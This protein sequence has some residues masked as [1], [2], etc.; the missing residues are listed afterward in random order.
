[1]SYLL[2][3][4]L[5]MMRNYKGLEYNQWRSNNDLPYKAIDGDRFQDW[6]DLLNDSNYNE[7]G[8]LDQDS[9]RYANVAN[10]PSQA[11]CARWML[12]LEGICT[13]NYPN[14][15]YGIK[16]IKE[17]VV[18][19]LRGTNPNIEIFKPTDQSDQG[20]RGSRR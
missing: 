13:G 20:D 3:R 9:S 18:S 14:N 7:D 5:V 8:T 16:I 4:Y 15:L 17:P 11:V 1:M 12:N 2:P 19:E 6:D 10:I